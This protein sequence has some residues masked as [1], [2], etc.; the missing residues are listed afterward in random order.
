MHLIDLALKLQIILYRNNTV[1]HR[2]TV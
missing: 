2:P 1:V